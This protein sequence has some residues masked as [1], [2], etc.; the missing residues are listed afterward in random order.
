ML[1]T[2]WGFWQTSDGPGNMTGSIATPHSGWCLLRVWI[3]WVQPSPQQCATASWMMTTTLEKHAQYAYCSV[4][5]TNL[6]HLQE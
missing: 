4:N 6:K 2:H 3:V 5:K 1:Q